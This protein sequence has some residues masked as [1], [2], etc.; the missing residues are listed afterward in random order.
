MLASLTNGPH[1]IIGVVQARTTT[2]TLTTF[3][4]CLCM[5]LHENE[6]HDRAERIFK[7]REQQKADAPKAVADYYAAQQRVR[8]RTQEL[9]R[10]RLE[11]E[12]QKKARSG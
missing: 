9:R 12:A 6:H 11:R 5:L 3:A 4:R 10:L 2:G 8:E 7:V 1:R